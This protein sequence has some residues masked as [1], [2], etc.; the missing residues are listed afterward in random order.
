MDLLKQFLALVFAR[1]LTIDEK[2]LILTA[3]MKQRR[4]DDTIA[5]LLQVPRDSISSAISCLPNS[6]AQLYQDI[7]ALIYSDFKSDGF[8][9]EFGATN[10]VDLSNTHMLEKY[11]SWHGILAEPARRWHQ[12]LRSNRDATIEHNC[13]WRTSGEELIFKETDI[14][15]LSTIDAFTDTDV[16][17]DLRLSG[18]QYRVTSISLDDLLQKHN[19]PKQIDFLSIDTEGSELDILSTFPFERWNICFIAVEHNYSPQREALHKLLT[20]NGY[21]RVH[22]NISKFD[23]WYVPK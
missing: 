22:Q 6:K 23:D 19:A 16:N 10:G 20:L 18:S 8:Y 5:F 13:V 1:G 7:A 9:V 15:E 11:F 14:A 12:D 17:R 3:A 2:R 4:A 21:K